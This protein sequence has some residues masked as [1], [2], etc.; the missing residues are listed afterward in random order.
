MK[1]QTPASSSWRYHHCTWEEIRDYFSENDLVIIP[2]GSCE[3][4]GYHLPLCTDT[5]VPEIMADKVAE[6]ENVLIL[7]A[8]PY[9]NSSNHECFPGTITIEPSTYKLFVQDM[10]SSLLRHGARKFLFING[11]SGNTPSL[12]QVCDF[13]REQGAF[14]C[15]VDWFSVIGQLDSRYSLSGHADFV[16]ASAV[17][18]TNPEL[19]KLERARTYE[20]QKLSENITY[21]SWDRLEYNG[22]S[23]LTWVKTGDASPSGNF[24]ELETTS[25][26]A[27][28]AIFELMENFLSGLVREIKT[29]DLS[30]IKPV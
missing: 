27:G 24:G 17:M 29:I 10:A 28:K 26:A 11:H 30:R 4:H 19:V 5:L 6:R 7:P 18:A 25:A 3:Q 15:L 22:V 14:A 8:L 23:L 9:G 2:V 1:K 16:E 12:L 20:R 13:L 21:L